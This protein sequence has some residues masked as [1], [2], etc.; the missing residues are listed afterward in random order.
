MKDELVIL[1]DTEIYYGFRI[2]EHI[3]IGAIIYNKL[4]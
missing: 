3:E 4:I 1:Q 2:I